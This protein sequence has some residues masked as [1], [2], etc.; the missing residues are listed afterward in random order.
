MS[1]KCVLTVV[2]NSIHP[3]VIRT[4]YFMHITQKTKWNFSNIQKHWRMVM[5]FFSPLC[6]SVSCSCSLHTY[7]L[8]LFLPNEHSAL[9]SSWNGN[10]PL[11]FKLTQKC[12]WPFLAAG[13]LS[14]PVCCVL[15]STVQT[16][17][18][19]LSASTSAHS[20]SITK[21]VSPSSSSLVCKHVCVCC[22][23]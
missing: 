6:A 11:W 19:T 4:D 16:D 20:D 14:C 5:R 18:S 3:K 7:F 9:K 21:S 22:C 17:S 1:G 13:I 15:F 10:W 23:L 8:S 12:F 2:W